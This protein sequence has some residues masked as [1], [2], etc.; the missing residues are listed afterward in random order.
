MLRFYITGSDGTSYHGEPPGERHM[1]RMVFPQ[2]PRISRES[3]TWGVPQTNCPGLWKEAVTRS[4]CA[5]PVSERLWR[6]TLAT[7]RG[8]SSFRIYIWGKGDRKDVGAVV[9][10]VWRHP[11]LGEWGLWQ[12]CSYFTAQMKKR[13]VWCPVLWKVLDCF[14]K[15]ATSSM[16]RC[17]VNPQLSSFWS[18]QNFCLVEY[19]LS[20]GLDRRFRSMQAPGE[21]MTNACVED[22]TLH[23]Q[24]CGDSEA[25]AVKC[26]DSVELCPLQCKPVW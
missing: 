24:S 9:D 26:C 25:S 3:H 23:P 8:R 22:T 11:V 5:V 20:E 19:E 1:R 17:L 21:G 15:S 14:Q 4:E 18:I 16:C 12:L 7:F 13:T 2:L 10:C 6:G